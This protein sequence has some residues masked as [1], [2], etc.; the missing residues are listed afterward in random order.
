MY[1]HTTVTK[2]ETSTTRNEFHSFEIIAILYNL[3]E[4]FMNEKYDSHPSI[5]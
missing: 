1:N 3:Y 5:Q 4:N 2:T